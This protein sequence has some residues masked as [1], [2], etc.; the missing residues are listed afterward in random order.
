VSGYQRKTRDEWEIQSNH[1]YGW[2]LECTEETLSDAREQLRTYRANVSVPVRMVKRRV[3][4]EV[5][6]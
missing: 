1:G 6:A 4:L 2:D 5:P 3:R